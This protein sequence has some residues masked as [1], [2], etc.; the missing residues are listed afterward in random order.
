MVRS[1]VGSPDARRRRGTRSADRVALSDHRRR[2]AG[3]AALHSA[4]RARVEPAREGALRVERHAGPRTLEPWRTR[5]RDARPR[6]RPQ[7]HRAIA[8]ERRVRVP[9]RAAVARRSDRRAA[10]PRAR[11]A[12]RRDRADDDLRRLARIAAERPDADVRDLPHEPADAR[13]DPRAD[14]RGDLAVAVGERR[15]GAARRS[16]CGEH[17]D[18]APR[19]L[20]A[21]RRATPD[22]PGDRARCDDRHG[23][24]GARAE[25]QARVAR[26]RRRPHA[27]DGARRREVRRRRRPGAA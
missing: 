11:H 14:A 21:R 3:G 12:L 17:A 6:R 15:A 23:G 1:F 8:A 16:R 2:D 9:R 7:A 19:R 18:A 10:V 4:R 22:P 24:R 27:R 26:E 20:H 13:P 5:A 25:A